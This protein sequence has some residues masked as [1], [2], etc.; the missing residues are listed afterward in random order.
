MQDET[1][2]NSWSSSLRLLGLI[3]VLFF[4]GLSGG[5]LLAQ[6][7]APG[8]D[9]A[10][11]VGFFM[12]P[13]SMILGWKAWHAVA[14][15]AMGKRLIKTLFGVLRG[16]QLQE[17]AQESFEDLKGKAP[18]GTNAFVTVSLMVSAVCGVLIGLAPGA[19]DFFITFG[20]VTGTGLAYGL[21]LRWLARAGH[22]PLP[23]E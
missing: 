4:G 3:A 12:L 9:W 13:L 17:A 11:F 1:Q 22:L 16:K 21:L 2:G 18:P 19:A 7:L 14:A 8:S 10:R 6:Q 5:L 23:E 20:V 15:A